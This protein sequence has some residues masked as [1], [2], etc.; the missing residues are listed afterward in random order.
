VSAILTLVILNAAL[1]AYVYLRPE[2]RDPLYDA[3]QQ[4]LATRFAA[5]PD[6]IHVVVLGSSR[7][8][9][10]VEPRALEAALER[11]T[12]R[13]SAAFNMALQGDGPIGQ[14]VH[15]RRLI[16][17]GQR[18]DAM[19]VELL[20]ATFSWSAGKPYDAVVLRPDRITRQELETVCRYGFP[21]EETRRGWWEAA[22]NP[23]SGFRFQ[24]LA[25][26]Q[27]K[28]LPLG[29]VQ[30]R[31]DIGETGGWGPW[32]PVP[33]AVVRERLDGVRQHYQPE[34]KAIR[35]VGPHV[36]AYEDLL[37][38]AR[39]AGVRVAIFV[40]PEGTEFRSWYPPAVEAGLTVFLDRLRQEFQV[41]AVDARA[42]MP[43]EAFADG[44]HVTRPWA[45]PFTERLTREALVP[46]LRQSDQA[47]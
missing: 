25:R 23:W 31:R 16:N 33:E 42:W 28:W 30:H 11:E 1:A 38:E 21:G 7:S 13:P 37:R 9:A 3:K 10:A 34:L 17:A 14:L 6:G 39:A 20:P 41:V 43:D 26:V 8:A 22:L 5:H 32:E 47:E 15:F 40:P 4:A 36:E 19:V 24:L 12:G 35:W 29:I 46:A 18:P 27:P 45:E 44:H 2:F